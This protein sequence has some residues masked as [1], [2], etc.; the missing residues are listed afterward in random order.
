MQHDSSISYD[1][2]DTKVLPFWE[3]FLELEELKNCE[4]LEKLLVGCEV[5]AALDGVDLLAA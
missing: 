1:F 2:S 3:R 4:P 5:I